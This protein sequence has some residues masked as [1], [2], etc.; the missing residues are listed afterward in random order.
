MS[1]ELEALES[2]GKKIDESTTQ[3][4]ELKGLV[5]AAVTEQ[6]DL[7]AKVEALN[8]EFGDIKGA[9][10]KDLVDEV[11]ELKAK[12]GRLTADVA[13]EQKSVWVGSLI[14]NAIAEHGDNFGAALTKSDEKTGIKGLQLIPQ[15]EQKSADAI[16]SSN[17]SGDNYVSYLDW[18]PG[19]EPTGQMHFR[20]LVRTISS[21]GDFVQFPRANTPIGEG[22]F[23][24]TD[25]GSGKPQIDRDYTMVDL[26]LKPMAG[27]TILSRQSLRNIRFLQSWLP[28]SLLDQL[29]DNED[30]DFSNT[31]LA[32]ATGDATTTETKPIGRLVQM[33]RNLRKK[34]YNPNGIA[35]DPDVWSAIV[36]NTETNAGFNLPRIVTVAEDGT[37][38]ILGRPVYDV[39]WLSNGICMVGDWTKTAIIQSE[40]LVLRQTDAHASTFTSNQV[41]MLLER[42]EGLAIFRPD[43]FVKAD[44]V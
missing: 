34:K 19:M 23:A 43:A 32:G 12:A 17:L 18:M 36:L 44:L 14:Q 16:S 31:L 26:T 2:L 40:G 41:T 35:V 10:V 42:T 5:D 13:K 11:K 22:S 39:N 6:K 20:E 27:Y 8:A 21:D 4:K 25:E 7:K 37:V 24:R 28:V 33:I 15:R 29:Q 1:K 3:G 38:R 30:L 9:T